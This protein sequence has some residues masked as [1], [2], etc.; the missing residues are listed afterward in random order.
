MRKLL[1]NSWLV[2]VLC[3]LSLEVSAAG[4]NEKEKLSYLQSYQTKEDYFV[5]HLRFPANAT[6]E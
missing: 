6:L 1:L 5:K 2:A 3:V 4:R